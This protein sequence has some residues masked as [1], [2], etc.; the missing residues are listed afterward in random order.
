MLGAFMLGA[1]MRLYIIFL[2]NYDG[3]NYASLH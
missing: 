1:F 2:I 3:R